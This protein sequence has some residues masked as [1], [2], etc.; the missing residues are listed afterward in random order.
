MEIYHREAR[1][2]IV[3]HLNKAGRIPSPIAR[4]LWNT[5]LNG[6]TEQATQML[7]TFSAL[8]HDTISASLTKDQH[9]QY[10]FWKYARN[11]ENEEQSVV[12]LRSFHDSAQTG[13]RQARERAYS[14]LVDEGRRFL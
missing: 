7:T 12:E 4:D 5:V 11:A 10:V 8:T 9:E 3:P 14:E 2:S 6:S 1:R 13:V